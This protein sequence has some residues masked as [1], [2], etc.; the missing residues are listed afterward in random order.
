MWEI[1][2]QKGYSG[3]ERYSK[4]ERYKIIKLPLISYKEFK[5]GKVIPKAYGNIG[6]NS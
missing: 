4:T 5:Y 6:G 2:R 3:R 1:W